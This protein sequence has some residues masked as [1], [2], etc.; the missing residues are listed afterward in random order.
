[1]NKTKQN[2]LTQELLNKVPQVTLLFWIIKILSTTVGETAADFLNM[3]LNFGL[4]HTS[5]FMGILLICALIFQ[6]RA[7]KYIPSLYWISVVLI[8][9]V[10]TLITDNL[11][12]KIG[13]SLIS[14]TL[15]F[16]ALLLFLFIGW[17]KSEKTLSM[18]SITTKKRELFYWAVIL[19]TFSLGTAAGDLLAET[20]NVG[21]FWSAVIFAGTIGLVYIGY[22]KWGVNSVLAFWASYILTRPL[23]ASMGDLLS[24]EKSN[25]GLGLGTT[26]T[27]ALFLLAILGII[28]YIT[29]NKKDKKI[30]AE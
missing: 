8:S 16:S 17:Y 7:K 30:Y 18:E 24:Q 9:V 20:L 21:Y 15:I 22:K 11:T 27:S 6:I 28:I 14:S 13:V 5:I 4:T 3:N 1:M 29:H 2:T 25:G 10:G 23:G 19:F 12:D 26:M